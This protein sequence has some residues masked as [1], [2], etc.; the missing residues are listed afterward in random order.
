MALDGVPSRA[1]GAGE[2]GPADEESQEH[3]RDATQKLVNEV[4]ASQGA[5]EPAAPVTVQVSQHATCPVVIVPGES[6]R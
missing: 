1:Y 4:L 6:P 2:P 5:A 3:V